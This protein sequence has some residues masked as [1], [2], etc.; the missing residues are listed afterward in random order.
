MRQ[1]YYF[2]DLDIENFFI[3]GERESGVLPT[4]P[5]L[6]STKP[7]GLREST[8][9]KGNPLEGPVRF[10][11]D[12]ALKDKLKAFAKSKKG[13]TIL[14]ISVG[15]GAATVF[16]AFAPEIMAA[17]AP[18]LPAMKSLLA[19]KGISTKGPADVVKKFHETQIGDL[20]KDGSQADRAKNVVKS[21]LGF[22]KNAKDRRAAGTASPLD[23]AILKKADETIDKISNGTLSVDTIVN[24]TTDTKTKEAETTT[25]GETKTGIDFKIVLIVLVAVF[26]LSKS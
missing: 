21:I 8:S 25:T 23:E 17:L 12:G 5:G 26:F 15:I 3:E 11:A 2:D 16:I 9:P 14:K 18:V 4:T 10:N 19:K 6:V 22:F 24:D 1:D 20:P 7:Q 13:K